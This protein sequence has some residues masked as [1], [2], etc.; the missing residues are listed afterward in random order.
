MNQPIAVGTMV[1]FRGESNSGKTRVACDAAVQFLEQDKTHYV[2]FVSS[3]R[4]E[5]MAL[6]SQLGESDEG[7]SERA[8]V[9][10]QSSEAGDAEEY[11]LPR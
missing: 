3:K 2:I 9:L 7:V 10:T 8:F 4:A 1:L 11:L 5:A 6:F